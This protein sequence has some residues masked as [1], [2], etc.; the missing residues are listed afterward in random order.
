MRSIAAVPVSLEFR[1]RTGDDQGMGRLLAMLLLCAPGNGDDA[2][3]QALQGR[4][5][6]AR[7]TE[8]NGENQGNAQ[9]LEVVFKDGRMTLTPADS[10][11]AFHE[12]VRPAAGAAGQTSIL[13][14]QNFYR[15]GQRYRE[16]N[17]ADG[18]IN[19]CHGITRS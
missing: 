4:W 6:G 19:K 2:V 17:A 12:E 9:K 7:Y 8:G 5:T 13:L 11:V 16:E 18:A 14:S 3:S 1:S 10:V 15:L